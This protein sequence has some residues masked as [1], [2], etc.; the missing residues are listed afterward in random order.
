MQAMRSLRL[1]AYVAVLGIAFTVSRRRGAVRSTGP[2]TPPTSERNY[3]LLFESSPVAMWIY[4]LE[5]LAILEANEAA[6]ARYGHS[7][8]EFLALTMTEIEPGLEVRTIGHDV[9]FLERPA[10]FV[11]AEDVGERDRL[12]GQLRQAQR[13][14]AI[15][16]FASGVAH[17]FNN[18]VMVMTGHSD[19]LLANTPPDDA[20]R[21]QAEEIKK[22]AGRAAALTRQLLTVGRAQGA[23]PVVLDLN[24]TVAGLEPMLR[25]S[26]RSNIEIAFRPGAGVSRVRADRGQIEQILVDLAVN[27]SDAMPAGGTLTIATTDVD[28]DAEYFRDHPA[29]EGEPGR[30][31]LLEV[32]DTGVGIDAATMSHVFEP[33]HTTK[34]EGHGTGLGL[35][36]VYGIVAESRGFV[37]ADSEPGHGTSFKVYLPAAATVVNVQQERRLVAPLTGAGRTVL[38]VEDDTTV[39]AGVRRMLEAEGFAILEAAEGVA[40]LALSEAGDPDSL[41]VL[42]ADTILPGP[43]GVDLADRVRHRHPALRTVIMSG[44]PEERFTTGGNALGPRTEFLGKPF[45]AAD[46][47]AKLALL[48]LGPD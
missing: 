24:A 14:E 17:E 12:D 2:L 31:T 18:L 4:D 48:L 15:A 1:T 16:R 39:R 22:A 46:L 43:G 5:T 40:A 20:R 41:G 3:R 9:T 6:L 36:A 47:H 10:R 38:L 32:A 27:A 8:D 35:A 13:M 37:S 25:R 21:G 34:A 23:E 30:Y 28:L 33:F 44:Y 7:R 42:V 19:V 29:S 11:L 45:T 26:I